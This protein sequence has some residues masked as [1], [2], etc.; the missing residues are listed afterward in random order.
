MAWAA[1]SVNGIIGP[2]FFEDGVGIVET[3]NKDR[4][5]SFLRKKFVPALRRRGI[6]L[7]SIWFQKD[8]ATPHTAGEVITWLQQTF[9]RRIISLKTDFEWPPHS[10]DLRPLDIFLWGYLREC[11]IVVQKQ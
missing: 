4:H 6:H 7:D 9:G 8:E 5:L 3:V 2:F 10:P 1:I 11:I